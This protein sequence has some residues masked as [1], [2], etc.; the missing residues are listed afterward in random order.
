MR[1]GPEELYQRRQ[2]EIEDE[3]MCWNISIAICAM[4]SVGAI[5]AAAMWYLTRFIRHGF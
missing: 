5:G 4:L 2:R 1:F 3:D